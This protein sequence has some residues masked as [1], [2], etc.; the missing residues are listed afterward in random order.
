MAWLPVADGPSGPKTK[1]YCQDNIQKASWELANVRLETCLKTLE[2]IL[3][4][5]YIR[6]KLYTKKQNKTT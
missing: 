1:K 4:I 3:T 6:K 5:I 2:M